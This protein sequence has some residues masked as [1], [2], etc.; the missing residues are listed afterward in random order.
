MRTALTREE[1]KQQGRLRQV[2]RHKTKKQP[3]QG[4]FWGTVIGNCLLL[5]VFL[6]AASS[7]SG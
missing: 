3:F 7:G 1:S 5:V 2:F 4:V 6:V